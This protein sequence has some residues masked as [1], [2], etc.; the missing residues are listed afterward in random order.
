MRT[1]VGGLAV[2][3][4]LLL[5]GCSS[6]QPVGAGTAAPTDETTPSASATP[7]T[8]ASEAP[9]LARPVS[10]VGIGCDELVP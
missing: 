5:G 8:T 10:L 6:A 1:L 7:T 4:V 2:V 3:A 9:E